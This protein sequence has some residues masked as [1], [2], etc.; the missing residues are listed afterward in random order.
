MDELDESLSNHWN[1]STEPIQIDSVGGVTQMPRAIR[2]RSEKGSVRLRLLAIA[3]SDKKYPSDQEGNGAQ[4]L[5]E[6]CND[7]NIPCWILAKREAENYL[8]PILLRKMK[9]NDQEH[10]RAVDAWERLSDDQKNFFNMKKG[11]PQDRDDDKYP[12]FEGVSEADYIVLT[13][14]FFAG[15]KIHKCWAYANAEIESELRT[16]SQGDLE[17]GIGL[18]RKEV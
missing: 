3:D 5:R 18:I 10:I 1:Q 17:Y 8:P 12:L 2:E 4:K 7:H 9:P 15:K 14:G 16:R 6:A 13:K 11:L